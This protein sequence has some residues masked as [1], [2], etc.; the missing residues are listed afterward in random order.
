MTSQAADWIII[1]IRVIT[2]QCKFCKL[3]FAIAFWVCNI[4]KTIILGL[5]IKKTVN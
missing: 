4:K 3:S 2:V 1:I 5:Y